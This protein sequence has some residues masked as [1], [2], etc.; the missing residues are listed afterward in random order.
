[1]YTK[2]Q[3]KGMEILLNKLIRKIPANQLQWLLSE[4]S[5]L[6]ENERFCI[7][8]DEIKLLKEVIK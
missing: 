7:L 4:S 8:N 2:Q 3:I 1:M 5:D 6:F